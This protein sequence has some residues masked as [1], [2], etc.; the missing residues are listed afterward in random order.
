MDRAVLG[1]AGRVIRTSDDRGAILLLD[2]RFAAEQYRALFP[3][4]WY[5]YMYVDLKNVGE[6]LKLFWSG[7]LHKDK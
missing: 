2:E 6:I 3:Q 4:E 7:K 5:P 1:S